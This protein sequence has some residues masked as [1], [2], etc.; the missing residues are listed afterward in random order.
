[1]SLPR[2]KRSTL[3]DDVYTTLRSAVLEHTLSP[4]D[5][6]NIDALAR[7]HPDGIA[8]VRGGLL[9]RVRS[10]LKALPFYR[11]FVAFEFAHL[12]LVGAVVS[13]FRGGIYIHDEKVQEEKDVEYETA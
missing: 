8:A 6:M 11:A 10:A 13:L 1:M 7:E 3:G 2:L 12:A 5:R 4:G 9:R